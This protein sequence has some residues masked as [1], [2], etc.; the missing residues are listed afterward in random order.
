LVDV[1]YCTDFSSP[2][3]GESALLRWLPS[4]INER[5]FSVGAG[6]DVGPLGLKREQHPGFGDLGPA[7]VIF[8]LSPFTPRGG[9]AFFTC[10][11]MTEHATTNIGVI[12]QFFPMRFDVTPIG[13][14]S[15]ARVVAVARR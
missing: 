1:D 12:E 8:S 4:A 11:E 7:V 6:C 3:Q 10:T 2:E 9:E 5:P 13:A 14:C 15:R